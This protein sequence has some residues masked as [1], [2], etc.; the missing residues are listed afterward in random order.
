MS[1]RLESLN[2]KK[3]TGSPAPKSGLKFKPK[4]VQRKSKEERD[5][6]APVIKQEQARQPGGLRGR[7]STRGGR[8]RGGRNTYA[9]TH[10]VT[11]GPL[12]AG[13]VS[14]GN[15]NGSKA[16]LTSDSIYSSSISSTPEFLQSLKLKDKPRSV[17]PS[18]EPEDDED[19]DDDPTRINMTEEYRFADE[20]TVLFPVRPKRVVD[21]TKAAP[22]IVLKS[23]ETTRENTPGVFTRESTVKSEPIEDK[24]ESIKISKAKLEERM[25]QADD[26]T[27]HEENKL[28]TDHQQILDLLTNKLS[29][30]TTEEDEQ[31]KDD[32]FILFQLPNYL[33]EYI[34]K[35]KPVK[36]EQGE[37]PL[38][39]PAEPSQLAVNKTE[40]RGKIGKINIHQSGKITIDLGNGNKLSVTKGAPTNFLQELACIEFDTSIAENEDVEMLD[41]QG[42]KIMGKV[43]RLGT[44]DEKIIATPCIE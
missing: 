40:L 21:V 32:K 22:T 37:Q 17:T 5:K 26:L 16:G 1:N 18:G 29:D 44:V 15:V 39:E 4:V 14:I 13:S 12:S 35:A 7:G 43:I 9:G 34:D 19:E 3:P 25:I 27:V 10:L 38:E 8:G 28:I 6:D 33:P 36:P 30:L 20:E 24:I 41:E 42:R 11:S 23:E 31:V 2:S